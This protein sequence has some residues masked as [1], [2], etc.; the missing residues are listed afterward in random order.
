[1]T[2]HMAYPVM[3][4][5]Q[6]TIIGGVFYKCLSR[7]SMYC[8][9]CISFICLS[10]VYLRQDLAVQCRLASNLQSSSLSFL[11]AR[12]IGM[13]QHLLSFC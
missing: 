12:I 6:N 10:V 3:F 4:H 1:M 8:C 11:S 13:C 7:S 9:S 2:Q 5:V